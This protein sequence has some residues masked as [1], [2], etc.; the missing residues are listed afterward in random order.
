MKKQIIIAFFSIL[1]FA[2]NDV[3]DKTGTSKKDSTSA[4]NK[5]CP[6]CYLAKITDPA[7]LVNLLNDTGDIE[8][9]RIGNGTYSEVYA[10]FERLKEIAPD[11]TLLRLTF[12]I[13]PKIRVYAM[14][15]LAEK[16]KTL[17]LKELPRFKKDSFAI[18]YFSGDSK[19]SEP[20][21][22]LVMSYFDSTEYTQ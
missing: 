5:Y 16:N 8:T 20:V 21:S 9:R 4:G 13:N 10:R 3:A 7:E 17:A 2:C 19:T 6:Y 14:W 15:A 18:M 22:F 1:A 12:H 11:T